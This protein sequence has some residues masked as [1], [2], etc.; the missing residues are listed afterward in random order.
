MRSMWDGNVLDGPACIV[1]PS[2][3][4]TSKAEYDIEHLREVWYITESPCISCRALERCKLAY[5]SVALSHQRPYS[6]LGTITCK[7]SAPRHTHACLT[8]LGHILD[9]TSL[10]SAHTHHLPAP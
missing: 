10:V 3:A 8:V 7:K 9:H 5:A 6:R 1:V 4:V 2:N